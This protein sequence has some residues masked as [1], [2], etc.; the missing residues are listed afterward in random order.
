MLVKVRNFQSLSKVDLELLP[1]V[2]AIVGDGNVGKTAI[3]R[4]LATLFFNQTTDYIKSG[5]S[6][7]ACSVE[8][9]DHKVVWKKVRKPESGASKTTYWVDGKE[10][11]KVGKGQ[12]EGVRQAFKIYELSMFNKK[13]RLNFWSQEETPFLMDATPSKIFEFLST[14]SSEGNLTD[15]VR[16]MRSELN[17][18]VEEV[19]ECEGAIDAITVTISKEKDYLHSKKGFEK[20][21][22]NILDLDCE[23]KSLEALSGVIDV[24]GVS[25]ASGKAA[26]VELAK[27]SVFLDDF[28]PV[29]DSSFTLYGCMGELDRFIFLLSELSS[30]VLSLSR[31]RDAVLD[32]LKNMDITSL[33]VLFDGVSQARRVL[34]EFKM[35]V[36]LVEKFEKDIL[37]LE[38]EV[39]VILNDLGL[40]MAEFSAFDACPLCGQALEGAHAH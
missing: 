15:V 16:D 14:S 27:T 34:T 2:T 24:A 40:V 26:K 38:S 39:T 3:F 28:K 10:S 13:V 31:E 1:G 36:D 37:G 29:L 32:K 11:T 25:L 20:V 21:Y 22:S 30:D 23:K 5:T 17:S 33:E 18:I 6:S 12:F 7:A 4:S 8:Y 19:R 35:Q 9:N